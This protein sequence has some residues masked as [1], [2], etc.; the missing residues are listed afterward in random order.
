MKKEPLSKK[1]T[2]KPSRP[3]RVLQ[4]GEGNFLRAFTDSFIQTLNDSCG[5]HG[6]VAVIKPTDRGDLRRFTEQDCLYTVVLRGILNGETV[7]QVQVVDSIEEV[8]SPYTDFDTF[9]S[10]GRLDTLK[11]IISN[12]TEAGIVFS[13]TDRLE[14]RPAASFPGKLTQ[15]LYERFRW[16]AGDPQKGVIL[17]PV[18]L[19]EQN[20]DVLKDCVL[21]LARKWDLPSEFL[22]WL[23]TACIFSNTLVDRIVS[24]FPGSDAESF[25]Q[26]LGYTDQLLTVAEPF[27]LWV[28]E[29]DSSV[30]Q[31]I[32]P[33]CESV[34]VLFTENQK[35]YKERKVRILN[36][37]HTSFAMLAWLCGM[38]YVREAMH[39]ASVGEF[40][41]RV[42]FREVIPSLSMPESE[43]VDFAKAV[44]ER[45]E[46]PFVNH[47][48][49]SISLNSVSKWRTRCLPSLIA[50]VENFGSLPQ[51][52]TFSL[53]ALLKFY[54]SARRE[55]DGTSCTVNDEAAV[56]D[57]FIRRGNADN[58][59]LVSDYLAATDFHGMDLCTI[60]GLKDAVT[61]HLNEMDRNGVRAALASFL[62]RT[63]CH[64]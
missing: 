25:F 9:L 56:L 45:F 12:T 58:A 57:F 51:C 41:H 6:S 23:E 31:E 35:P 42:L 60:P 2:E 5:F 49:L 22:Q 15:L 44:L 7:E 16:F 46:N 61:E 39:D 52:L 34:P 28:I 13:E 4:F 63:A 11:L 64:E 24:G 32:F 19:I 33:D 21:R 30:R 62:E 59:S 17:L 3:I 29:A 36:G 37:A 10:Y 8:T 1:I 50:Y 43:L 27:G 53:A 14:D 38:D 40:I 54:K 48:L 20:G 26:K 55:S 18:E 47:A